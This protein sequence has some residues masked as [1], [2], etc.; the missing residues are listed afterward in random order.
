MEFIESVQGSDAGIRFF[1][2]KILGRGEQF[3]PV[4]LQIAG[5]ILYRNGLSRLH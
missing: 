1:D 5:Q 2:V 4:D 3:M